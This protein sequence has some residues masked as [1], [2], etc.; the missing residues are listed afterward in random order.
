MA[1]TEN[2]LSF[3]PSGIIATLYGQ[4]VVLDATGKFV[5]ADTRVAVPEYQ[6]GAIDFAYSEAAIP[7]DDS[8]TIDGRRGVLDEETGDSRRRWYR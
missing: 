7:I 3:D 6:W 5:Y 4:T 8:I 1:P 2:G